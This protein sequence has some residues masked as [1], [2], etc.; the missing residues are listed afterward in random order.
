MDATIFQTVNKFS[1]V[2]T[3]DSATRLFPVPINHEYVY[4]LQQANNVDIDNTFQIASRSGYT[5]VKTG[6]NVHSLW[7][8]GVICLYVDG[9]T[10]YKM[11]ANYA[12]ISLLTG[13]TLNSKVSYASFNDRTY[14]TNEYQIGYVKDDTNYGL[15]DPALEFKLPL[16]AGQFIDSFMGCLYVAK[17]NVL[18]ISDPLCDYYDIRVGYRIFNSRIT[19]LR[20][21]E[22]GIYLSDDKIWFIKG[23]GNE[24]FTRDDVYPSRA[25]PYTD[26]SVSGKYM[27][28]S[29]VG[30]VAIWTSENGICL[31]DNS[32]VVVN[33]TEARYSLSARGNG[34]GFIRE[35]QNIR[36]YI[37]SLY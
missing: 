37:N 14:Y 34:T 26:V 33:L 31:G 36:H 28:D 27:D 11:D 29:M 6:A 8:D 21:V 2:N 16:P 7:S 1:G 5:S 18:Y 17:D 4:P 13:L 24:D 35:N 3:V 12:L 32:G 19:M 23:K 30:N 22:E 15:T 9:T 20:A 10:L 25:I